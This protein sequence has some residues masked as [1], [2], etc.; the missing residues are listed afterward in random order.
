MKVC[1]TLA[2][3]ML[4]IVSC[5]RARGHRLC[6]A[7][8]YYRRGESLLQL[9]KHKEA[10]RDFE[11]VAKARPTDTKARA[12]ADE[13]DKL[14]KRLAFEKAIRIDGPEDKPLSARL[15]D[16]VATMK[17]EPKYEGP[18]IERTSDITAEFVQEM[19]M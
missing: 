3:V 5:V 17:I 6:N 4:T 7:L 19:M 11:A 8:R 1:K 2:H 18:K 15:A 9:G 12:K 10:R 13:V 16:A 14:I